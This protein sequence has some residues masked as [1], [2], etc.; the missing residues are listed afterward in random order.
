METR[1]ANNSNSSLPNGDDTHHTHSKHDNISNI[2]KSSAHT[3]LKRKKA[4]S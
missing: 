2:A 3:D 4:K 1:G